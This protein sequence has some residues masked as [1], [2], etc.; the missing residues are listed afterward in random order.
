MVVLIFFLAMT[1]RENMSTYVARQKRDF[2]GVL[3]GRGRFWGL[4]AAVILTSSGCPVR[5]PARAL[6]SL[7]TPPPETSERLS[8]AIKET[9]VE[10]EKVTEYDLDGDGKTEVWIYSVPADGGADHVRRKEIDLNA[11]G[12]PDLR[13]QFDDAGLLTLEAYDSDGDGQLEA[14]AYYAAGQLQ[15]SERDEDGDGKRETWVY[16]S[17]DEVQR[18]DVDR[19]G[20]GRVDFREEWEGGSVARQYEDPDGDGA[21][22]PVIAVPVEPPPPAP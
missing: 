22:T 6:P 15:R 5:K 14:V 21:L 18:I 9:Q 20:D 16:Y 1:V 17:A 4:L 12:K 3:G 7:P 19:D 13:K 8:D 10:G 2:V 11:D